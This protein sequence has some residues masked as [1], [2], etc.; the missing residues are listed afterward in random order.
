MPW[1]S[2]GPGDPFVGLACPLPVLPGALR[3]RL[4]RSRSNRMRKNGPIDLPH[5][6]PF[7]RNLAISIQTV[8]VKETINL[9]LKK[10]GK[11]NNQ[12]LAKHTP[13][14]IK[15][16]YCIIPNNAEGKI[17]QGENKYYLTDEQ[18][19]DFHT[20]ISRIDG[21]QGMFCIDECGHT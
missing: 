13:M 20:K 21:V 16:N 17:T 12:L 8:H 4:N 19:V 14:T 15:Y 11:R 1:T 9:V 5:P 7:P 18:I 6:V 10:I 2:S 3:Q